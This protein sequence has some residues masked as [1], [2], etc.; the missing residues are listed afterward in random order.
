MELRIPGGGAFLTGMFGGQDGGL[1]GSESVIVAAEPDLTPAHLDEVL[2]RLNRG[3]IEYVSLTHEPA[4]LQAAGEGVGPY[5]LEYNP[6]QLENQV[7]VAG[8]VP[9]DDVRRVFLAFMAGDPSWSKSH[10]WRNLGLDAEPSP[11]EG[12]GFLKKLFGKG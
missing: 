4:F 6:G 3:E 5:Q 12:G 9:L 10:E 7:G 2:A 1:V 8:G 11:R